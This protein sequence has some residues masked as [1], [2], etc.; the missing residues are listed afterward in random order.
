MSKLV[1]ETEQALRQAVLDAM[2]KAVAEGAL[3]PEP[4]PAF[5]VEVP[6]DRANGDYATNAAMAC[7]KAFRMTPRK[8]AEEIFARMDLAD[9]FFSRCEVAGPGFLNFFLADSYYAAILKDIRACGKEYGRSD[10]GRGKRVMVEFV[11]ANPTGPMH[12]GNAR[13]GAL[14]DCLAAALDYAG[15]DV[16]REFYVNDAG[17]QIEKFALSLEVRYLQHFLGEDAVEL[18]RSFA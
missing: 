10:Y 9:T 13:G 2:G 6:A 16:C 8:I 11:S 4:V 15:F 5:S 1:K 17:N 14:G 18:P 7:A 12:M 3:P